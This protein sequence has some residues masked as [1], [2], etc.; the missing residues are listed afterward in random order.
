MIQRIQS[1]YLLLVVAVL[2]ATMCLPVGLFVGADGSASPFLNY[3]L[4]NA[5]DADSAPDFSCWGMM[6]LLL[7]S[8]VIALGTIFLY[9]NRKLQIRLTI[10]NMVVMLGWYG[11]FYMFLTAYGNLMPDAVFHSG[12]SLALPLIGIIL[13]VMAI[14]AIRK[15]ENLV[16]AADRLR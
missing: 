13:N 5:A 1:L 7:L 15:D 2:V 10:F 11:V 14:R 8:A 16:K 9:K 3:G 6:A 12:L 4:M